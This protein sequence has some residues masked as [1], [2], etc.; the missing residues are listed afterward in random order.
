MNI[1]DG[2]VMDIIDYAQEY[3]NVRPVYEKLTRKLEVLFD[4]LLES[5]G[6]KATI[7]SRTKETESIEKQKGQVFILHIMPK[8]CQE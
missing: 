3:R 7:E 4:E 8:T 1:D 2:K 6:I 5:E